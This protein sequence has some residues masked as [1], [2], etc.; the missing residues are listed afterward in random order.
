MAS[1]V[2]EV[3]ETSLHIEFPT[4]KDFNLKMKDDKRDETKE[5][6]KNQLKIEIENQCFKIEDKSNKLS[7]S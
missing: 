1:I 4:W 3:I 7:K 6:L 5:H 2:I